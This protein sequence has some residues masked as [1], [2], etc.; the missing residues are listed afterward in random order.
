MFATNTHA[1]GVG[2][3]HEGT[4]GA[5]SA[6][7]GSSAPDPDN[8]EPIGGS[9]IDEL[10]QVV[11]Y[12]LGLARQRALTEG[13]P[14]AARA[15]LIVADSFADELARVVPRFDAPAFVRAVFDGR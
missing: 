8:R 7:V 3:Q 4:N 5:K 15:I 1:L 14:D 13:G 6:Q 12:V 9:I 10:A 2:H 11:A